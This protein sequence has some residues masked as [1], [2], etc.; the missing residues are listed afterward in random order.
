MITYLPI[1]PPPEIFSLKKLRIKTSSKESKEFIIKTYRSRAHYRFAFSK[2][3][4][5]LRMND[6]VDLNLIIY[7]RL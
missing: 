1:R 6:V 5:S 7:R 4:L 3:M 2:E